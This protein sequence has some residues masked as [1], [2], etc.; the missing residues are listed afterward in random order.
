MKSDETA[1]S[2]DEPADVTALRINKDHKN[3]DLECVYIFVY[4]LD[5]F[6]IYQKKKI[7]FLCN[8]EETG[9]LIKMGNIIDMPKLVYRYELNT[10][11]LHEKHSEKK[12]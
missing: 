9:Q 7:G 12:Q 10:V 6:L 5:R 3:H 8:Y 11:Y 4:M 1:I 2:S